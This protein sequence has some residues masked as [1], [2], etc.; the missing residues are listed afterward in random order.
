MRGTWFLYNFLD[1]RET[2]IRLATDT[3]CDSN[4]SLG[5]GSIYLRLQLLGLVRFLRVASLENGTPSV[6]DST[7]V[8]ERFQRSRECRDQVYLPGSLPFW[9]WIGQAAVRSS[10]ADAVSI[11]HF[12][13]HESTAFS[14]VCGFCCVCSP[15]SLLF[16]P[17]CSTIHRE[18]KSTGL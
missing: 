17:N 3:P 13:S 18:Q 4:G 1:H 2:A 11:F 12:S 14:V 15:L 6:W 16:S 8:G 10:M 9:V 5:S 7:R